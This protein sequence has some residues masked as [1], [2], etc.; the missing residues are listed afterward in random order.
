MKTI[1]MKLIVSVLATVALSSVASAKE[2]YLVIYKSQQGFAAMNQYMLT[3]GV[4]AVNVADS[5]TR[6]VTA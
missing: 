6:I 5:L 4:A 2:R 3:E 1:S